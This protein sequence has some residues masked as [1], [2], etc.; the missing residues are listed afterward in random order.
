M[1]TSRFDAHYFAHSCGQPYCRN[2]HWLRFFGAIADRIVRDIAPARA[3][4][5]GCALGLLVEALRARGVDAQGIDVSEYAIA[6]VHDSVKAHCRVGSVA[7]DLG[8]RYDLIVCIEVLEH[9]P[10]AE[11]EAA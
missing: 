5:A 6:H 10:A 11:A 3:L 4:D 7:G 1:D 2:E 8:G 9:M